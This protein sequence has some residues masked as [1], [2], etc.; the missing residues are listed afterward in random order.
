MTR[1]SKAIFAL[2]VISLFPTQA[3]AGGGPGSG[4]ATEATQLMNNAELVSSV[5]KQSQLVAGQIRDYTIQVNQYMTMVKNLKQLPA[6]TISKQ[7]SP[8]RDS[9]KTAMELYQAV[10]GVYKATD[11]AR[12]MLASRQDELRRLNLSPSQYFTYENALALSR[13]GQY[14]QKVDQDMKVLME[15]EE[16]ARVLAEMDT[17]I[18]KISGSVEGLQTL[19]QQNQMMAGELIRMNQYLAQAQIDRNEEKR[20]QMESDAEAAARAKATAD[21]AERDRERVEQMLRNGKVNS[22]EVA[23]KHL[24]GSKRCGK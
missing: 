6:A 5:A 4:G 2:A 21:A 7:L 17:E 13:G 24:C 19:A 8:Y 22:S 18:A 14:K 9:L 1:F 20:M 11:Q 3:N 15:A 10:D 12:R 16:K 23:K